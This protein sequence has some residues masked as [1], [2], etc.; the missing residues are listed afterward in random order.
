MKLVIAI[1]AIFGSSSLASSQAIIQLVEAFAFETTPGMSNGAAYITIKNTGQA[2]AKLVG[3]SSGLAEH[4]Q[5]HT[6]EQDG[7]IKRMVAVDL[8]VFL[9]PGEQLAMRPGGIHIMFLGI[10]RPMEVGDQINVVI[11]FEGK[12]LEV[13]VDVFGLQMFEMLTGHS[14]HNHNADEDHSDHEGSHH[15]H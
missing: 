3:V 7:D 14:P 13:D 15:N 6:H 10:K 1:L 2:E 4:T 5:I 12:N 9:K 8:P 11:Q